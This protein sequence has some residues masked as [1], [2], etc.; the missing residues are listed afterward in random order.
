MFFFF[1]IATYS[2]FQQAVT[3]V[4]D[5]RFAATV[6]SYL[7]VK[8][9]LWTALDSEIEPKSCNIYGLVSKY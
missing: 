6:N 3:K 9:E 2:I 7:D 4:V 8:E 1:Q 5:G